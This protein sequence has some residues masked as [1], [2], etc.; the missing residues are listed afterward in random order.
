MKRLSS[1]SPGMYSLTVA[2]DL[3]GHD[4]ALQKLPGLHLAVRGGP[5]RPSRS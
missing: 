3:A 2:D 4:F 1:L 5:D